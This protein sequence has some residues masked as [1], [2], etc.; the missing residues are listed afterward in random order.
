MRVLIYYEQQGYGG[1]DTHLAHLVNHWPVQSDQL[2]VVSNPDNKGL[3]FFRNLLTNPNVIIR[4]IDGVFER[5]AVSSSRFS[6]L[7]I[8][9]SNNFRFTGAFR[10]LL[11]ELTPDIILSNNGGYPGG[12]TNWTAA[13]VGKR[14]LKSSD[15]TFLLVHHAP[16]KKPKGLY[17]TIA[18]MLTRKVLHYGISTITVSQASKKML[19]TFTPLSNL[20]VIYN[21][22]ARKNSIPEQYDF[23]G[24]YN[25]P[26]DRVLIGMIGPIDPH[27]GHASILEVFKQSKILRAKAHFIVVGSGEKE[28]TDELTE[29]AYRY[30]LSQSVT[31]TGF[32]PGDSLSLISGFDLLAMPTI[33]FEGFGYSMAEAMLSGVP[34][35]ASRVGAIPEVIVNG[36]SGFLVEPY[37][38]ET[39]WKPVLEKLVLSRELRAEIGKAGKKRVEESFSAQ[40]MSQ[41]YYKLLTKSDHKH[42]V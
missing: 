7:F 1:V 6:R 25:I 42:D 17:S 14:F 12:L 29:I 18:A 23:S 30:G 33:D 35:V 11:K 28:L 9:L 22:I 34:V 39:G 38:V 31:F 5:P 24:N 37:D 19:E 41:Q 15:R 26:S 2:F 20:H 4:T 13:I 3:D 10:D 40:S 36:Q 8:S 32:L 27:K 16:T 21:G